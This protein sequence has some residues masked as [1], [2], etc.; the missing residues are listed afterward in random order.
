MSVH[1]IV[2][3]SLHASRFESQTILLFLL[4][5]FLWLGCCLCS[6]FLCFPLNPCLVLAWQAILS[7]GEGE[8][9]FREEYHHSQQ[10]AFFDLKSSILTF[11]LNSPNKEQALAPNILHN[12]KVIWIFIKTKQLLSCHYT[13]FS[14]HWTWLGDTRMGGSLRSMAFADLLF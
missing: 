10:M 6:T 12:D 4:G 11:F 3:V 13:M 2:A 1:L 5:R 7:D 9:C 14:L 8:G